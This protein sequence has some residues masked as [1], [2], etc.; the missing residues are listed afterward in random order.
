MLQPISLEPLDALEVR[1]LVDNQCD[2]LLRSE[3]RAV[4]PTLAAPDADRPPVMVE[5]PVFLDPRLPEMLI[6]EH[7]FSVLVTATRAGRARSILFDAGLSA[8]GLAHNM[9]ALQLSLADVEAIVLSHGHFDHIGGLSGLLHDA[10]RRGM[11]MLL[12]PDAWLRR[13]VAPP[14]AKPFELPTPSRAAL[15]GA[16]F[17]VID[18]RSPSLLLD[19]GLLI[20]GEVD[21]TTDF[22]RGFPVHQAH[23]GGDWSPDPLILDDQA[24]IANVRDRGLVI[25]TGCG[26]AGIVNIVRHARALTGETRVHAIIGGFHLNGPAFAASIG[27]T[28]AALAEFAP[29]MIVPGH[30]T[31]WDAA[32]AIAA[33]MPAAFVQGSVGTRFVL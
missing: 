16:G 14:N 24:L 12:H 1:L 10:G 22:E 19:G 2:L 30:C 21:R 13:R 15:E 11:P 4:R 7:G 5:A 20:T 17:N 33:A 3:E 32:V 23:R 25:V 18:D 26:H 28:V 9:S 8:G 6:A 31:G 29:S 27:P